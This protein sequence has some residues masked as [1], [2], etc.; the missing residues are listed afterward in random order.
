MK[1]LLSSEIP[2]IQQEIQRIGSAFWLEEGV[3]LLVAAEELMGG[4]PA[5]QNLNEKQGI[6]E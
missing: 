5:Q 1:Q 6:D 4:Y 2:K 3:G